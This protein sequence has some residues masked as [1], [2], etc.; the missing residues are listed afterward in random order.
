MINLHY[1]LSLLLF[2]LNFSGTPRPAQPLVKQEVAA[3]ITKEKKE[4]SET[5]P[6]MQDRLLRWDDF[7]SNP[8]RNSDAVASTSTSLGLSYKVTDDVLTFEIVCT[9]SKTK[10]WGLLKTD[11]ILAHE[12]GHFDITE[13]Y[14]RKLH[15]GL[16]AYTF[17]PKTYQKDINRIYEKA[18]AE[19]EHLQKL[20]DSQS[21][22]SRNKNVQANWAQIIQTLLTETEPYA[23]YP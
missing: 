4:S 10:S 23:S 11:Y 20:Y 6:W 22:H 8:K 13:V 16:T 9:F 17:N 3:P 2:L 5:I 19:K 12:Q 1:P 14:A 7:K 21:D 18:V 15:A